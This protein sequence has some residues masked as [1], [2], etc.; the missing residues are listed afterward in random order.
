MWFFANG[1]I[2]LILDI[3]NSCPSPFKM[4][5]NLVILMGKGHF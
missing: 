5:I 4:L 2:K 3:D 1:K